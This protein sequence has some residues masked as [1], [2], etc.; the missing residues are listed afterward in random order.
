MMEELYRQSSSSNRVRKRIDKKVDRKNVD[1]N[2][3]WHRATITDVFIKKIK[4]KTTN[5]IFIRIDIEDSDE[6]VYYD[7][8]KSKSIQSNYKLRKI[9]EG[10]YGYV[11]SGS[12]IDIKKLLISKKIEIK[13]KPLEVGD[14]DSGIYIIPEIC[15]IRNRKYR[16]EN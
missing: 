13:L 2:K 4:N 5:I 8:Y 12:N 14:R 16:K 10:T 1:Y 9:F 11:P 3:K 7:V 15:E 6:Y